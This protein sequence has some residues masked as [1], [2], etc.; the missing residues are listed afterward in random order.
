MARSDTAKPVIPRL[1]Q[2]AAAIVIIF[3]LR[4]A[5][6]VLIPIALAV[7]FS[8]LLA[9]LV[10]R[11]EKIKVGR[12]SAVLLVV[13]MAFAIIGG[14]GLVVG[15]QLRDLMGKLPAYTE[16]IEKTVDRLKTRGKV[17]STLSKAADRMTHDVSSSQPATATDETRKAG[18]DPSPATQPMKVQ[19][20]PATPPALEMAYSTFGP[21]LDLLAT[22]FIVVVLCIFMLLDREGLR[23][24]LIRLVSH[25]QL[26]VTTQAMDDAATRV[27]RYLEMQALT[28]G[29]YGIL[30]SIGLYF[31]G[32]PNPLLW[33]MMAGLL[34][35][36]PYIGPWLGGS[37]PALL[38]FITLGAT[39][40]FLTVGMYAALE[41]I[42]SSVVEPWLY[43]T[44]T[45]VS[46][47]AILVAA[48]FWAWE[49]GTVGLLLATPLTVLLVVLGKHV[50][51]LEFL[52]VMLG[53]E[54]V[55][56]PPTRY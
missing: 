7:L 34:R 16:T 22:A 11:V 49:W 15:A 2:I 32:V 9:P 10:R 24:R 55:F 5:K 44:H 19:L 54:P 21:V 33:G 43:G 42:L 56:D 8:F 17:M 50:P 48:I 23:D 13:L 25:G 38:S 51:A 28:N 52:S 6:E 27:S 45:G 47:I 20:I 53:D 29:T 30:V 3:S 37:I 46:S 31:I 36:L 1:V 18:S 35:F 41:I 40:G 4:Y 26:N 39:R 14:I 12:V